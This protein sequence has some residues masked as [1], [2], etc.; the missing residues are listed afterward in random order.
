MNNGFADT[1]RLIA[2]QKTLAEGNLIFQKLDPL[3]PADPSLISLKGRV[4]KNFSNCDYMGFQE[5]PRVKKAAMEAIEKHGILLNG[6]RAYITSWLSEELE[7]KLQRITGH[8]T[9]VTRSTTYASLTTIPMII[10]SQDLIILDHQVHSSVQLASGLS[11]VQGVHIERIPHNDMN[12]LEDKIKTL[13]SKYQRIWYLFDGVYSM[14]GDHA[15]FEDIARLMDQYPQLYG[16][17]DD[18]WGMC[19]TGENGRGLA[20]SSLKMNPKLVVVSSLIKGFGAGGGGMVI[21]SDEIQRDIVRDLSPMQIFSGP[22]PNSILG[23]AIAVADIHLSPEIIQRQ[24]VYSR[25][26]E[27]VHQTA[28]ELGLPLASNDRSPICFVKLGKVNGT[29]FLLEQLIK[30]GYYTN[31][32]TY[33]LVPAKLSGVRIVINSY[34]SDDDLRDLIT[35]LVKYYP[36]AMEITDTMEMA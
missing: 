23:S 8:P 13:G 26:M 27:F 14:V 5:D 16:Y 17:C 1:E 22:L 36:Q 34:V 11:A 24:A 10:G 29:I 35:A 12:A 20:L 31:L 28:A 7:S 3:Q 21:F 4:L 33:P 25:R 6:S 2:T 19:W 15:C 30:E 9:F 32:S 18:A